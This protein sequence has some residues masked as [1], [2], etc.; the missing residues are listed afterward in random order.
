VA[1]HPGRELRDSAYPAGVG[2]GEKPGWMNCP[3]SSTCSRTS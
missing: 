3:S 2:G 1:V